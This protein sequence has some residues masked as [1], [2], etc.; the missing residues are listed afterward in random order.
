MP[1][2]CVF[3]GRVKQGIIGEK[4]AESIDATGMRWYSYD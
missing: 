3:V 1:A 2:F 4:W